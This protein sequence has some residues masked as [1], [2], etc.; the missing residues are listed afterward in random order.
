[1]YNNNKNRPRSFSV[2]VIFDCLDYSHGN[3]NGWIS[4]CIGPV[5]VVG[6]KKDKK[7]V[8]RNYVYAL[9]RHERA[10]CTRNNNNNNNRSTVSTF[11]PH[12]R[13]SRC[14][15]S[16]GSACVRL[17][18]GARRRRRHCATGDT[19]YPVRRTSQTAGQTWVHVTLVPVLFDVPNV[20]V[21]TAAVFEI[22]PGVRL[23]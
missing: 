7:Y 3:D 5:F 18:S 23:G 17:P 2:V 4:I 21:R 16:A 15:A 22:F 13:T 20:F 1:M 14:S 12:P 10:R 19:A 6:K 8:K 11:S 9:I